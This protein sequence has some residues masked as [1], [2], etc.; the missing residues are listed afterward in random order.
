MSHS[1]ETPWAVAHQALLS[2]GF[3]RQEYQSRLPFP[4]PGDLPNPE[5][6]PMSHA[7]QADSLPSELPE[8][9]PSSIS[10]MLLGRSGSLHISFSFF[11]LSIKHVAHS[12]VPNKCSL[13]YYSTSS[14]LSEGKKKF[15]SLKKNNGTPSLKSWHQPVCMPLEFQFP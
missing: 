6:K 4:A 11:P 1:F 15:P 12:S 5:I 3:F 9:P 13:L 14:S 7:L 10:H 2:M 8:K